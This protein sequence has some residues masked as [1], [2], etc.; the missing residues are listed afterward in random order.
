MLL[1]PSRNISFAMVLGLYSTPITTQFVLLSGRTRTKEKWKEASNIL[2]SV[3][4]RMVFLT[5]V[6][7][8]CK[9]GAIIF[10]LLIPFYRDFRDVSRYLVFLVINSYLNKV[11]YFLNFTLVYK[12]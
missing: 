7:L 2:P 5:R 8:R 4:F 12:C 3:K 6:R 11:T 10:Q 1:V 9:G